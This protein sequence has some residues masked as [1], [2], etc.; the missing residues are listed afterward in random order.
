[1]VLSGPGLATETQG[2]W[3]EQGW[4]RGDADGE[5]PPWLPLLTRLCPRDFLPTRC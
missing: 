5:R 2:R 4:G 1:M 3:A